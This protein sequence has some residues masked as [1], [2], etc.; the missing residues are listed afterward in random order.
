MKYTTVPYQYYP[1]RFFF[2][3]EIENSLSTTLTITEIIRKKTT[4]NKIVGVHQLG[5][6]ASMNLYCASITAQYN[7]KRFKE[8]EPKGKGNELHRH[9]K[10]NS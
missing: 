6:A 8:L 3:F 1:A 2:Y 5:E 10:Y 9:T 4:A 7:P